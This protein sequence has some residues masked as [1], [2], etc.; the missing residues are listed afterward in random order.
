MEEGWAEQYSCQS[1]VLTEPRNADEVIEFA[2][3]IGAECNWETKPDEPADL[4]VEFRY[5]NTAER[6]GP[7][8]YTEEAV[9]NQLGHDLA[10]A[11]S[12]SSP[13]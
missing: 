12:C 3:T 6:I 2:R 10:A 7:E 8:V 4:V 5:L 9:R 13:R 1:V 11:A